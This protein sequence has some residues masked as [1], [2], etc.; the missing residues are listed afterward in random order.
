MQAT[1]GQRR[2]AGLQAVSDAGREFGVMLTDSD[3]PR[4]AQVAR[5]RC[6]SADHLAR[7]ELGKEHWHPAYAN[8][9]D[10]APTREYKAR[11][12]AIKRRF[13]KLAR[14]TGNIGA[15]VGPPVQSVM[16]SHR[17]TGWY[18]TRYGL[19]VARV[20]WT[21]RHTAVNPVQVPHM[22]LA[23]D[24]GYQ[25]EA[26]GVRVLSEREVARSE[27]FRGRVIDAV[28][29][30][31]GKSTTG[32]DVTKRPDVVAL[33]PNGEDYIAIEAERWDDRALGTYVKKLEA[34]ERNPAIHKVW[35]VC[36]SEATASR[37]ERAAVEA[38]V[39]NDWLRIRVASNIN[40]LRGLDDLDER[41]LPAGSE[42]KLMRDL[43]ELNTMTG[44]G[45]L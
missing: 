17:A 11:V 27:D 10:G 23:A 9:P 31:A 24:I 41:T 42:P 32:A 22:W 3:T 2:K 5:W 45:S 40:G 36:G 29:G 12:E 37:V 30:S 20:P 14:I 13:S 26:H 34:Y 15:H 6:L 18:T 7:L 44:E 1:R 4:V 33:A 19:S 43:Q 21:M 28:L 39:D 35:Y 8:T 16:I 38:G 25:V